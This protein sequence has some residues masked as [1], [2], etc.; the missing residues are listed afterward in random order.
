MQ[1]ETFLPEGLTDGV[2]SLGPLFVCLYFPLACSISYTV[3]LMLL[4]ACM[5]IYL[6]LCSPCSWFIYIY[7]S[8]YIYFF[9]CLT[10]SLPI[11]LYNYMYQSFYLTMTIGLSIY[12]YQSFYL[13]LSVFLSVYQSFDLS[14]YT[15]LQ[16]I[17]LSILVR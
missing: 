17:Y 16:F 5:G 1:R 13:C 11:Y 3:C 7:L 9:I 2:L 8:N 12:I 14:N 15:Y 10:I 6:Y 4:K